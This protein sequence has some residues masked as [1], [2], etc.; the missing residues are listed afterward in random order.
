MKLN[1]SFAIPVIE[2]AFS[3]VILG[4]HAVMEKYWKF[5]KHS[6]LVNFLITG[7]LSK[8]EMRIRRKIAAVLCAIGIVTDTV[9]A[10][11]YK[12]GDHKIRNQYDFDEICTRAVDAS[13]VPDFIKEAYKAS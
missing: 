2:A 6:K 3:A 11:V 1:K 7:A 13:D 12:I 5:D 10:I 9:S 8:D 4:S